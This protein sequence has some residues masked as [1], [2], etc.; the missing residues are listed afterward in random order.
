MSLSG[1]LGFV[2]L[3]EVLRLLTRSNQGGSV[4]VR[5]NQIRGRV[6][7]TKDGIGLATTTDDAGMHRHLVKSGL[8]DDVYLK[9][10]EAGES[11]LGQL[12]EK[13]GDAI[14]E[15]LREMTV[16]S[17]Y[18]MGLNGESFEVFQDRAT[19][20][21]SPSPFELE[22]LINDAKAR[23]TDWVDVSR[24]VN[25]LKT[26]LQFI[27]NLGD[28]EDVRID[29]DGWK[30]LS[31]VGAGSS[32]VNMADE[33]GTTEFWTA[34]VAA[35]L[36]S[37]EL[38]ELETVAAPEEDTDPVEDSSFEQQAPTDPDQSWWEEPEADSEPE[39]E[40]ESEPE[41]AEV[42]SG[43]SLTERISAAADETEEDPDL[44]ENLESAA[45]ADQMVTAAAAVSEESSQMPTLGTAEPAEVEEDTEAFLE[46]VFSE[47]ESPAENEDEGYGLLRRRRMGS[48]RD[49]SNDA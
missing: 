10:V 43:R 16:E 42:Q 37:D 20:Y 7:I 28:R 26:P 12:V 25:D 35:R 34:R 6:F 30:V 23:L 29:R 49:G 44:E 9:G 21:G 39:S 17:L 41:A 1:N 5:G 31:E 8:V 11:S 38:V 15:L 45:D 18:Q 46:K 3:D 33:L 19:K 14:V 48:A 32:V 36:I 2:S 40:L 24:I 27:R 4:D 47:L 22:E 13:S